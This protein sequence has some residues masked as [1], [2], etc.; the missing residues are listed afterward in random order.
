M[1]IVNNKNLITL[2]SKNSSYQ[3]L[4]SPMGHVLH[5]YY[6]SRIADSDDMSY[7]IAYVDR[8]NS[9]NPYD[10]GAD[11]TYSL[12]TLPQEFSF[13]GGGDYR[14]TCLEVQNSD[15]VFCADLRYKSHS[16]SKGKYSIPNLP[17]SYQDGDND[18]CET[19]TIT[20]SDTVLNIEVDLL[21]SIFEEK[22]II[23]RAVRVKNLGSEALNI[24]KIY[25]AC[26]DIMGGEHDLI[27]FHGKHGEERIPDRI[28][29]GRSCH[30][31]S[32]GRGHSSH[33]E[34][35]FVIVCDQN[36]NEDFGEAYGMGFV[37]SGNFAAQVQKDAFQVT[38]MTMGINSDMFILPLN[39]G[40]VFDAP[41]TVM[42]YSAAGL[43]RLSHNFHSFIRHNICRGKFKL[44]RRPVLINNWEAT[45]FDFDG[46][47]IEKI[48]RT[49]SELGVEMFVLDDG[50]FGNRD[51]D[52]KALGDWFV[53]EEKLGCTMGELAKK[54]NDAGM[55]FGLWFEPEM[56]NENSQLFRN[57]PDWAF[58]TP[59]RNPITGRSQLVL[60]FSRKEVVDEV[61]SMMTKILDTANIEYVKWDFNRS[62]A[63]VF[64][65][66][67]SVQNRGVILHNFVLGTYD[68]AE[69]LNTRYPDMYI[70]GCCGGGGRFDMGMMYYTPQIWCSDNTDAIERL[71]IQYGT[72]FGY[73][74]S[75]VG[76]HVSAV[77]NHQTGRLTSI[78]T[79]GVV[80]M[81]G[82]FGYE[83]DLGLLNEDEKKE[84]TLQIETFK[85]YWDVIH[86]G[87]YYRLT[88]PISNT[89]Y[90][91]WLFVADDKSKALLNLVKTH[92][93]FSEGRIYIPFKGLDPQKQY[94]IEDGNVLTGQTFSGAAL[95]GRGL[96]LDYDMN[97]YDATQIYI[98]EVK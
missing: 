45:Y 84:V 56:I 67:A 34:N 20:L 16:I 61:F 38:R 4:I 12:D 51:L 60:D 72:S 28:A 78:N 23:T 19:L 18:P 25:S 42:S 14:I 35:P 55:K 92:K 22:D 52:D 69:R 86:N 57:H 81:S 96:Y 27:M 89:E 40:E 63:D 66:T 94:L 13:Q 43:T 2:S 37:Y 48:A 88:N 73:P 53:N 29:I 33:H 62:I 95:M 93:H 10:A 90:C 65:A 76:S 91:A 77:P 49:A 58:K 7:S 74:T 79:R 64:S 97:E 26:L 36:A 70:E 44:T 82:S 6:G 32:S 98:T 1:A 5:T 24:H 11:R 71:R 68:L 47:K 80:A 8:G 75:V 15:G 9:G 85:K 17:A 87:K 30:T 46:E 41:E 3:M 54:V 21:Y 50:W 31:V 59:D 39:P 83:L